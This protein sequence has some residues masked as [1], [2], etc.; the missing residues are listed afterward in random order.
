M[1]TE[2]ETSVVQESSSIAE[3]SVPSRKTTIHDGIPAA[4]AARRE[5][6][7]EGGGQLYTAVANSNP[8]Y[9]WFHG[10]CP[11]LPRVL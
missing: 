4:A 7:N 6:D 9:R 11:C 3:E 2:V 1:G 8:F 10:F 5:G